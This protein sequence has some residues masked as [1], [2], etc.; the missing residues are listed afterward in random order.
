[1]GFWTFC[2][3]SVFCSKCSALHRMQHSSWT[4][5]TAG[6]F[7]VNRPQEE[8][9]EKTDLKKR[10]ER[11]ASKQ[12]RAATH[13]LSASTQLKSSVLGI[14]DRYLQKFAEFMLQLFGK[15]CACLG[16]H[17]AS[18]LNIEFLNCTFKE[19]QWIWHE[20]CFPN[21][22]CAIP[23]LDPQPPGNSQPSHL[24]WDPTSPVYLTED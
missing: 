5:T 15:E 10:K 18:P 19:N 12:V 16:L 3:R 2:S 20:P 14:I 17:P 13:P 1:M 4:W 8:S 21:P 22:F 9:C 23:S 24:T 11:K 7:G 6:R